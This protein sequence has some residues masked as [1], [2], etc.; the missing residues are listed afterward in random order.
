MILPSPVPL[1]PSIVGLVK[2]LFVSVCVAVFVVAV[3]LFTV[4]A[5]VIDTVLGNPIVNVPEFSPTVT[6]PAVPW[7]ETV[8]PSDAAVELPPTLAKVILLLAN[9]LFAIFV[10]VLSGPL[11]VLF[12]SICVAVNVAIVSVLMLP[13]DEL[14]VKRSVPP[15]V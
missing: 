3:S 5:V 1:N 13:P 2:V 15:P 9:E 4:S 7:N 11:I 10:N 14:I 12:V 8:S 6:S